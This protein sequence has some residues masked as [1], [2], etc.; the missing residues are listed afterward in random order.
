MVKFNRNFSIVFFLPVI[1]AAY[2]VMNT[3]IYSDE[4]DLIAKLEGRV[5]SGIVIPRAPFKFIATPVEH[6]THFIWYV[7]FHIDSIFA[8]SFLK[9]IYIVLSFY[10]ICK[11]FR[12]YLD[13]VSAAVVSFMF[14]FFPSH[15]STVY[16]FLA[17]YITLSFAFYFY[18]YYLA[19]KGRLGLASLYAFLGSFVSYGST[20]IAAA[21]FLL[22]LLEKQIKKGLIIFLPN[23]I[24]LFYYIYI[25][26]I[27]AVG[28]D[29]ISNGITVYSAMKEFLLQ[30]VSFI[31]ASFG[32]SMFLKI[33]Y[34]FGQI[35]L[36]S[37]FVGVAAIFIFF[38]RCKIAEARYNKKLILCFTFLALLSLAMFSVTGRYT[39][40]AFN[41][42]NRVTVFGSL[43]VVYAIFLS[44]LAHM[45]KTIVFAVLIFAILGVSDHWKYWSRRQIEVIDNISNNQSLKNYNDDMMI[46]VSGNQYSKYGSISHIEF[47]SQAWVP[48]GIFSV[49]LKKRITAQPIN[50]RHKYI[51]GYLVDTKENFQ[52]QVKD[53]IWIYDSEKNILFKLNSEQINSYIF[54]LP[55][56]IRHWFQILNI[57]CINNVIVR[58]VPRL[59]YLF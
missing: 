54:S 17:Q 52:M 39:Q 59:R 48:E 8:V 51:D 35:S 12:I 57:N 36:L 37:F 28:V 46:Y 29:K 1:V 13:K 14:L 33:Y 40:F 41:L 58:V 47:L 21:L 15:D 42:G 20:P 27:L 31:D 50:R 55:K 10:F 25:A 49:V 24:Y 23:I 56:D 34:S 6:F 11:F 16:F 18:S 32:P 7:F 2:L 45:Y 38:T 22:F 9:I 4:F 30:V 53:Y 26:K 5:F 3:G 43:L 19:H 44:P